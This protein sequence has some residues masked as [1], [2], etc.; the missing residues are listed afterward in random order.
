M[1]FYY[2]IDWNPFRLLC[3]WH[4]ER[5]E[6]VCK[7]KHKHT[8]TNI[9]TLAHT[10]CAEISH[11]KIGHCLFGA[12][13]NTY[14]YVHCTHGQPNRA[15]AANVPNLNRAMRLLCKDIGPA[16]GLSLFELI[17]CMECTRTEKHNHFKQW[18]V[19]GAKIQGFMA[20]ICETD[21]EFRSLAAFRPTAYQV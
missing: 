10:F 13:N 7:H 17:H 9:Y 6:Q 1:N 4:A 12:D 20:F 16:Y 8:Q 14:L 15:R 2:N 3:E 5:R 21:C 19:S 18:T 11:W